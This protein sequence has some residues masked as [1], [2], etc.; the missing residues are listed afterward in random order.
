IFFL[1]KSL[2]G[3]KI[4]LRLLLSF[5]ISGFLIRLAFPSSSFYFYHYTFFFPIV[6]FL[7][8]FIFNELIR[9]FNPLLSVAFAIVLSTMSFFPKGISGEVRKE[10]DFLAV[11][12]LIAK[13]YSLG[14]ISLVANLA[15]QARWDHNG[16]EYR[17][18]L[19]ARY[20]V[21]MSNWEKTDYEE[22]NVLYLVDEGDLKEPLKLGGM[23]MEAFRPKKIINSWKVESGQ[24]IYKMSK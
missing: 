19:E 24:K 23:E 3:D 14:K 22:A 17:Y 11:G 21:P 7:L 18:F 12:S 16:L 2:S 5:V 4:K 20:K 13:D 10:S 6:L 8:A 15:D 9:K 1:F